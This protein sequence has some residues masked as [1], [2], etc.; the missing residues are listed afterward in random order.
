MGRIVLEVFERGFNLGFEAQVGGLQIK[1]I[2]LKGKHLR[3]QS[4]FRDMWQFRAVQGS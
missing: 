3:V 4:I 1:A 2:L